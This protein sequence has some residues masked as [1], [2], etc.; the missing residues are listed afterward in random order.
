LSNYGCFEQVT[1][2]TMTP[3]SSKSLRG[4]PTQKSSLSGSASEATWSPSMWENNEFDLA[5]F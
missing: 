3:C 2:M 4:G 5:N 1:P